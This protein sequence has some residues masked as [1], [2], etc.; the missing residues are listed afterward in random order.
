MDADRKIV[1][2]ASAA[3]RFGHDFGRMTIYPEAHGQLLGIQKKSLE[4]SSPIDADER[5][6][7]EVARKVVGGEQAEIHGTGGTIN[8]Q[9][10]GSAETTSEFQSRLENSKGKGQSLDEATR[11]EME[12]R[13]G[14][15]F[16]RVKVHTGVEA[17][18]LSAS[19]SAKAFTYGSDLYFN[20]GEYQPASTEGK[21]LLAHELTHTLQQRPAHKLHRQKKDKIIT[22]TVQKGQNLYRIALEHGTTVEELQKLNNLPTTDIKVGQTLKVPVK[23]SQTGKQPPKQSG[24]QALEQTEKK[25]PDDI[26][27]KMERPHYGDYTITK[28]DLEKTVPYTDPVSGI[29]YTSQVKDTFYGIW[30][31]YQIDYAEKSA[32]AEGK[33]KYG[34]PNAFAATIRLPHEAHL[35]FTLERWNELDIKDKVR[36]YD[37]HNFALPDDLKSYPKLKA[38]FERRVISFKVDNTTSI[39]SLGTTNVLKGYFP[40][41]AKDTP[42]GKWFESQKE[43]NLGYRPIPPGPLKHLGN[44]AEAVTKWNQFSL[45][46]KVDYFDKYPEQ[47]T[48]APAK[49]N[50]T[51]RGDTTGGKRLLVA[52]SIDDGPRGA[53]TEKMKKEGM[54]NIPQATWFI[55]YHNIQKEDWQKLRNIQAAG[56]EIAIHS[57]YKDEDHSPWFPEVKGSAYGESLHVKDNMSTRMAMLKTFKGKLNE[58]K[59]YPRFVRV[60]GGLISE[61]Q[62]Y[63]SQLGYI[64]EAKEIAGAVI[65]GKDV[66]AYGVKAKQI[67]ADFAFLKKSLNELNLLLWG[68]G[69][70]S[71]NPDPTAIGKQEWT[72]ETSGAV[73]RSDYTTDVVDPYSK[74]KSQTNLA[75]GHG[76]FEKLISTMKAGDVR[77]MVILAHDTTTLKSG[78]EGQD[79]VRAVKEDRQYMEKVCAEKAIVLE[80]HTMSSLF[81]EV[82]GKDVAVYKPDY[83]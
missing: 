2:G 39:Q 63:A 7:D 44:N 69:G 5:E 62:N 80:Y 71:V 53:T 73:G 81:N 46:Q 10:E 60:P 43:S 14:A 83:K 32:H 64:S 20:S 27:G 59:I 58:E 3:P 42:F 37:N 25:E 57:F 4:V 48:G 50:V 76:S 38:E 8:R 72:T 19:I 82:T 79:D 56:G 49:K 11:R 6:A 52:W 54:G 70:L 29:S 23:T 15:D 45:Q 16:S 40:V 66:S 30:V 41:L 28:A 26:Y 67:A 78:A 33:N 36:F 13:M 12:S 51:Y 55:Q 47:K 68:S 74:T 31:S 75:G 65:A 34:T 61:L 35:F 18:D 1:P 24:K 77:G 9:G 17:H 22:I 21:Q